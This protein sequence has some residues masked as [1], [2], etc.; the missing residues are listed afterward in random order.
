MNKGMWV[1][2][3]EIRDRPFHL[4][5]TRHSKPRQPMVRPKG[6][7]AK[8]EPYNYN[9]EANGTAF[10]FR[11]RGHNAFI[12]PLPKF[13]SKLTKRVCECPAS[14]ENREGAATRQ[15]SS[16]RLAVLS[17]EQEYLEF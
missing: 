14:S 8:Q 9:D 4:H 11:L 5:G 6:S 17:P 10:R 13:H 16:V 12:I 7:C 1:G 2:P 15:A 3:L